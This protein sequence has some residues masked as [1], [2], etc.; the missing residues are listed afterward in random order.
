M[1]EK[2]L[3]FKLYVL[4]DIVINLFIVNSASFLSKNPPDANQSILPVLKEG[5]R[6]KSTYITFAL[7]VFFFKNV[8]IFKENFKIICTI[9]ASIF[10]TEKRKT[11][12]PS[13]KPLPLTLAGASNS[14]ITSPLTTCLG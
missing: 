3:N 2:Y 4:Y 1:Y 12:R 7:T 6:L 14:R 5:I 11:F 13:K 9:D 10:K 8:V